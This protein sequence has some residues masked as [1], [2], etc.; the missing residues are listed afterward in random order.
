MGFLDAIAGIGKAI[1]G[2]CSVVLQWV[3]LRNSPDMIARKKAQEEAAARDREAEAVQKGE[4]EKIRE[5]VS[6]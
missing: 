1:G 2:V 5:N 6:P 3:G 4:L